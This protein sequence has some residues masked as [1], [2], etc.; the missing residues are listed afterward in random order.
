MPCEKVCEVVWGTEHQQSL[1]KIIERFRNS[2][3]LYFDVPEE[4]KP[5]ILAQGR[6]GVGSD[7]GRVV[8]GVRSGIIGVE[9]GMV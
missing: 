5:L 6:I 8:V 7:Q 4:F 3:V 9:S 1:R 2:L